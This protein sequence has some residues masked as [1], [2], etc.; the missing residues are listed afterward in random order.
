[1]DAK[2]G[3]EQEDTREEKKRKKAEHCAHQA[4]SSDSARAL[5][6]AIPGS[7]TPSQR[8]R[9]STFAVELLCR[10]NSDATAYLNTNGVS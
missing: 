9:N 5:S 4:G 7:N 3:F 10:R 2:V 6:P 1:M 8:W